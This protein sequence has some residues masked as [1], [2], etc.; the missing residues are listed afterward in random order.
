MSSLFFFSFAAVWTSFLLLTQH[1]TTASILESLSRISYKLYTDELFTCFVLP[2]TLRHRFTLPPLALLH[3]FSRFFLSL[4]LCSVFY[5][6]QMY[7]LCYSILYSF[8]FFFFLLI[9][10]F[11]FYLFSVFLFFFIMFC[12]STN[13][14]IVKPRN[15]RSNAI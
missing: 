4:F 6:N 9:R 7:F 3:H 11:S 10:C 15:E 2:L 14:L 12:F 8:L 1:N 13:I 5:F